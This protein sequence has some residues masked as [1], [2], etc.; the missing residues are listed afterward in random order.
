MGNPLVLYG[1]RCQRLS[2]IQYWTCPSCSNGPKL[3]RRAKSTAR[4]NGRRRFQLRRLQQLRLQATFKPSPRR[5][6]SLVY[7]NSEPSAVLPLG[8][9][10]NI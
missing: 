5:L 9:S 8:Q 10:P 3:T 2:I 1:E 6:L 7:V 4:E